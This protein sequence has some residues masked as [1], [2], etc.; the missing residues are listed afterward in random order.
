MPPHLQGKLTN[1]KAL[2]FLGV[3]ISL[4]LLF[5]MQHQMGGMNIGGNAQMG[6]LQSMG[7]GGFSSAPVAGGNMNGWSSNSAASTGQTLSTN[8]WQ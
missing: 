2:T 7:G 8:L 3:L 1:L 5:Q 4:A 6:G